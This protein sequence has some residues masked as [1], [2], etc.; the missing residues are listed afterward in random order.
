M[1][2]NGR[3]EHFVLVFRGNGR[4]LHRCP[5]NQPRPEPVDEFRP[6]NCIPV[7]VF[8]RQFPEFAKIIQEW[9]TAGR[10]Y[11]APRPPSAD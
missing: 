9:D 2:E 5:L 10:P 3:F 4:L 8:E 7:N 11:Y 6:G 1:L